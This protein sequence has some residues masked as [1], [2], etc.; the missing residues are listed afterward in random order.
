MY[1]EDKCISKNKWIA[2]CIFLAAGFMLLY[3]SR[4][5]PGFA[6]WYSIHI[7]PLWTG[8]VGRLTGMFSFSVS[9]ILIYILIFHMVRRILGF[10]IKAIR[11]QSIRAELIERAG[12]LWL[13]AGILLFVYTVNC[14]INYHRE[15]FSEST[16]FEA[17]ENISK[18]SLRE[19]C[20]WLTEEVNARSS[21]V[22]R[23]K[24]GVMCLQTEDKGGRG[25]ALRETNKKAVEAMG[26]IS[27]E[28]PQLAGYYPPPKG[29]I[30][31]WILSVQQ[32]TG[33][34][35]P[36]TI[37]ANYNSAVVDY[38]IPFT[39]C[40]ELSHLKGYMQEEEANFIAFLAS[41]NS[42]D[43]SFQYSGFLMGWRYCMNALYQADYD[44]WEEL[45][46]RLS[47]EVEPDLAANREFWDKYDTRIAETA[48]RIN[49]T[50]LKA[51]N[52]SE[53]VNSYNKM[54]DLI[55]IYYSMSPTGL[56]QPDPG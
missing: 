12:M 34:Y 8:T 29:L 16:G 36:F 24:N 22:S 23:D 41:S 9:E 46:S 26:H 40:H 11:R 54:V 2:G 30:F 6:R 48:T 47:A 43:I 25:R 1:P 50:Y 10:V 38:N 17:E 52:Q 15:S 4:I 13:L 28:Y 19:V 53:G 31:P 45:R 14:G 20:A 21:M 39:A 7:Y 18:E 27:R 44:S 33:I 3:I 5:F 49:D 51:N 55:V 56:I 37:E 35:S 32:L 42:E